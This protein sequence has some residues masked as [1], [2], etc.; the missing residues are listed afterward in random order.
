MSRIDREG[1]KYGHLVVRFNGIKQYSN[2]F[3]T[4]KR[5]FPRQFWKPCKKCFVRSKCIWPDSSK[6]KKQR[7]HNYGRNV[8]I[9]QWNVTE[10]RQFANTTKMCKIHLHPTFPFILRGI[11]WV[12]VQTAAAAAADELPIIEWNYPGYRVVGHET[13]L[14]IIM[15]R[16]VA[17][18]ALKALALQ[19]SSSQQYRGKLQSTK[20]I[21]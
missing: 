2:L 4:T 18:K 11:E 8:P 7:Q 9:R 14:I 10:K 13:G 19:T 15:L 16:Q 5:Q 21:M 3:T 20:T 17:L 12:Q 1:V 6:S